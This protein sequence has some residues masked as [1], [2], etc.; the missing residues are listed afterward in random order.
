[1]AEILE[2]GRHQANSPPLSPTDPT[3]LNREQAY[4][5]AALESCVG[6]LEQTPPGRRN[7]RLNAIAYRLGRMVGPGWIDHQIVAQRLTAA[8]Q[9]NRLA[10]DDG[11]DSVRDTIESGLTAGA[12]HPHGNLSE[13]T[14]QTN[15]DQRKSSPT[16]IPVLWDG[17]ASPN[18]TKWLVRDLIPFGSVGL[19]VGESRAGKTFLALNLAQALSKGDTFVTSV[20]GREGHFTSPPKPRAP[21]RVGLGQPV[22]DNWSPF[23][24]N[25]IHFA[26]PPCRKFSIF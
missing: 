16:T 4:A 6:E 12:A 10:F 25:P 9:G 24:K 15:V 2:P 11:E 14:T 5:L 21:F 7:N 17:D 3:S 1:L 20:P 8:C 22:L 23:W 19:M 18:K 13:A 26:L